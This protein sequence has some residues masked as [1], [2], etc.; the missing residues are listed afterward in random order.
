MSDVNNKGKLGMR[1]EGIWEKISKWMMIIDDEDK[2]GLYV[3]TR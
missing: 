2:Y 3:Y 1:W